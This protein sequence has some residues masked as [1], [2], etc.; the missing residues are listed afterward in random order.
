MSDI[1]F[2]YVSGTLDRA[3][4]QTKK[5]VVARRHLVCGN[6][7]SWIH[8]ETSGCEKKWADTRAEGFVFTC[9][10]CTEVAVLVKEVSGLKQMMEDMKET[11]AGL[12][13]EDKEA[14]TGSRVTTTGVSQDR[15]ET[16]G[17]SRTE[18]TDTGIEDKGEGRTED[19]TEICAGMMTGVSQDREETDGNRISEDTDTGIEGEG[20]TEERTEICAGTRLMATHT[21]TK[22]QESPI[23]KEIDLQQWDTLI[24]KR[25]HTENE[26]WS[27]VQDRTGQVGYVPA[28]FLVVILDTTTE[29]QESDT[30]KKGQENSTEEN[31][32][33]QEGERRKSYSAAVID[34]RK[35]NTT[36]YVGDSII[37]KTDTRLSK[38]EDVVVCLPGGRI[39]HVTERV[40]KIVGRGNGGTILV[41]V[42]TN[43]TDKEGTT[44]IVEKYRKLLKKTK[45]AR[46]GQIILSGILPVCGNRIQGYRNSKRMA[47]NGMVERLCKEEEVGY[48]DMWDSFVG[49][50]ELYFRDGLHLSGKGAAVLA[51]GLSGAVASGLGK[52]RY[53]N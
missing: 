33:G 31:R 40:E 21:Y 10:G 1:S 23:G 47:V 12:H 4:G 3:M 29:E 32:I 26:N 49:N 35:R 27:L 18:D 43:N 51:E 42:G 28:G 34:G 30:T 22:N 41:H 24:F 2:V 46:L 45:Q 38:G 5:K 6:C 25:G 37:R 36:I 11:V 9:K 16:A 17:N 39:E 15:E 13:L 53:L 7:A 44:A 52:V 50:E 20:R 8:L 14:E 19:R 48:V